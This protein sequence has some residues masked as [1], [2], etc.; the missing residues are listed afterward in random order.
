MYAV[1]NVT[2]CT[3]T[4]QIGLLDS[5]AST[6]GVSSVTISNLDLSEPVI[7]LGQ[8]SISV[9][10]TVIYN[11]SNTDSIDHSF[12]EVLFESSIEISGL[13]YSFANTSL[14]LVSTAV[15][16]IDD[17]SVHDVKSTS[18]LIQYY[19]SEGSLSNMVINS[20]VCESDIVIN[21]LSSYNLELSNIAISGITHTILNMF[22]T[23]NVV[24]DMLTFEDSHHGI[25]MSEDSSLVLSNSAFTSVGELTQVISG[26]SIK[27]INSN[28]TVTNTEFTD[29]MAQKGGAVSLQ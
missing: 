16:N 5:Y 23:Y 18:S 2:G 7:K 24:A 14:L 8:S 27:S 12:I 19:D 20:T 21:L 22:E 15:G 4:N 25:D 26:G 1:I 3:V 28:L 29:N 17:I 11:I 9:D 10:D 6:L 13:E